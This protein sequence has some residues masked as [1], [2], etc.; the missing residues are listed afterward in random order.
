MRALDR[1]QG[2]RDRC[3]PLRRDKTPACARACMCQGD[4]GAKASVVNTGNERP[5]TRTRA[6]AGRPHIALPQHNRPLSF[7]AGTGA[8]QD[9]CGCVS[10][11]HTRPTEL[12]RIKPGSTPALTGAQQQL[13][14][15]PQ[16]DLRYLTWQ[17]S[18]VAHASKTTHDKR[19]VGAW[20]VPPDS[21]PADR[22]QGCPRQLTWRGSSLAQ[23]QSPPEPRNDLPLRLR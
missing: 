10:R 22:S 1:V 5:P 12:A 4:P 2:C 6:G 16:V 9:H 3:S 20:S 11:P 14:P 18:S 13:P 7:D 23:H 8:E 15:Q 21:N 19:S 17:G